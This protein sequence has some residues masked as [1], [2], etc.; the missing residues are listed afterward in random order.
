MA[1]PGQFGKYHLLEKI[2]T[3][4]MAEVFRARS[5][6][7]QG[8]E[9]I[10]VI[11]RILPELGKSEEFV[12]LFVDEALIASMKRPRPK[13]AAPRPRETF[14]QLPL[15]A[16]AAESAALRFFSRLLSLAQEPTGGAP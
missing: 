12:D 3:G 13:R 11:K 10:L 2:A 4:G 6:G 8:F 7:M 1:E 16:K 9:K 5:Y 15:G 14:S